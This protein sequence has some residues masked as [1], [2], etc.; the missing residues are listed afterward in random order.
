MFARHASQILRGLDR[1]TRH[2]YRINKPVTLSVIIDGEELSGRLYDV[3]LDGARLTFSHPI[4]PG[5]TFEI[6]H[7]VTGAIKVQKAWAT[8]RTIGIT[9]NSRKAAT[10]L[11]V[12]CLKLLVP[13]P[14]PA[15]ARS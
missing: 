13:S 12:H 3:S 8:R 2:R 11:C 4:D 14:R 15:L 5:S 10:S 7:P 6:E 9:F 1:R